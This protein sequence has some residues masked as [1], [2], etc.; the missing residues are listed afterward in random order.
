MSWLISTLK[1]LDQN[2]LDGVL[3]IM[4]ALTK[5]QMQDNQVP[6]NHHARTVYE[7]LSHG[8]LTLLLLIF[9][10]KSFLI[11]HFNQHWPAHEYINPQGWKNLLLV[12]NYLT[13]WTTDPL[14]RLYRVYLSYAI[15]NAISSIAIT[16]LI[17]GTEPKSFFFIDSIGLMTMQTIIQHRINPAPTA[18]ETTLGILLV[19]ALS[20]PVIATL[21]LLTLD[22]KEPSMQGP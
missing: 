8:Q 21:G 9:Y 16:L 11:K 10:L 1:R 17:R 7:P 4:K 19:I 5:A 18:K 3:Y 2:T 20:I 15:V 13:A 12:I 6:K 22:Y 14:Q